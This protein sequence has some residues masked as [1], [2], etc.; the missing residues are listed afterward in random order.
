V[1]K[2]GL[3]TIP[4]AVR[5]HFLPQPAAEMIQV[6]ELLSVQFDGFI[7]QTDGLADRLTLRD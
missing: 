5:C 1:I 4:R 3:G 7:R 6:S 2:G